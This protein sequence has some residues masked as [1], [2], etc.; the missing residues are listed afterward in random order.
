MSKMTHV[1]I[2]NGFVTPGKDGAPP[3]G[4]N[5]AGVVL[6]ADTLSDAEMQAIAAEIGHSETAFISAS[7]TADFR[8]DF[9]TPTRRIA[10]CGHATI[11][12]FSYLAQSNRIS[13]GEYSK[14]TIEGPRRIIIEDGAAYMEQLAPRY[15]SAQDWTAH[16]I[17]DD[18]ILHSLGLRPEHMLAG[19]RP[20]LV[21]TGNSFMLV[22]VATSAILANLQVN[23]NAI[24][25]I[26]DALD[27]IGYYVFATDT[28]QADATARMFAPRYGIPEEAATGMAAGPLACLLHD[29]LG[30]NQ[31]EMLILQG[32]FMHPPSPSQ[33]IVRLAEQGGKVVGLMAGGRGH[34]MQEVVVRHG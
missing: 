28:D 18:T 13:A 11:A 3:F 23:Q 29:D 34:A 9:F 7:Q 5:P 19:L 22:G 8:F 16:G 30:V 2:I 21:N 14:Q 10:H 15:Q 25:D 27:L 32:N 31:P 12:A 20:K 6:D 1:Q 4:G 17:T 26:S 33:I 24:Q